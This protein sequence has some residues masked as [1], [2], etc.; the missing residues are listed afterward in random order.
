MDARAP[1]D[2]AVVW[3]AAAKLLFHAVTNGQYGFHR[4]ELATLADARHL[5]WGYVAYPP[6]TPFLGRIELLLFGTSLTGF[7][8]LAALAQSAAI[9]VTALMARRLGGGRAAQRIAAAAVAIAPVSL[10]ASSLFQYVSFDYL[11]FVLLAFIAIRLFASGDGRWWLAIGLVIGVGVLT[12]YTMGLFALG[13]VAGLLLT[14]QRAQ[15]RTRWPWLGLAVSLLVVAPNLLWQ[16]RH[17]FISIDF[18]RFIHERDVRI[19]RTAGLIPEQ[20]FVASNPVTVPLWLLGLWVAFRSRW[21]VL[22]WMAVVPF[23]LMVA[24]QGRGYYLGPIYPMLFALGAWQLESRAAAWQPRRRLCLYAPTAAL[25]IL[26]STAAREI[27]PLPGI[28]SASFHA[29]ASDNDD[30][31]EQIGW[32]ELAREVARIYA[33]IPLEARPRTGILCG[34]YGEA[35]AIDL[36]GPA[37]GLPRAISGVN[38]Y[39]LRGPGNPPPE[40]LIVVGASRERLEGRFASVELAGHITNE[41]GVKNEETERHPDIFVCRGLKESLTDLWPRLR[42]FG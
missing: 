36:Y 3:L 16:A 38:S 34:N 40:T 30:I 12:K 6:L 11:W 32:P 41:W 39:W 14:P 10:G 29:L 18:L 37:L 33:T 17:D 28:G 2:R 7:R 9:V 27:L 8:F 1:L 19:G 22:G 26:G 5:D 31:A 4:D 35:G 13:L 24:L 23:G 21:R 25:L 15:L 42:S 20:F